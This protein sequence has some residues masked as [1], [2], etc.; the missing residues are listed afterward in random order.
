MHPQPRDVLVCWNRQG[1][2]EAAAKRY[3]RAGATVLVAENGYLGTDSDGHHLF[4][5]ARGQHNGRGWWPDGGPERWAALGVRLEPWRAGGR[6]VVVLCQRGIGPAGVAMPRGWPAD[7]T[8]RLKARCKRPVITRLHPGRLP[9]RE[10][11]A[12]A[13]ADCWCAVTWGSTA[14]LKALVMGVPVVTEMP[15][16][17]GATGGTVETPWRGDRQPMLERLAWAQW[18]AAELETGEPFK[19]LIEGDKTGRW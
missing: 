9:E 12:D 11:L 3:E 14:G 2:Y 13:L 8:A 5:L 1:P 6:D 17:I 4:A 15:G 7:V 18:S 19:R 16:W 10:P